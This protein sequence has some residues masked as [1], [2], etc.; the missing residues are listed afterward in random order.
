VDG[1]VVA[2]T[3]FGGPPFAPL[4]ELVF[5]RKA[6]MLSALLAARRDRYLGACASEWAEAN[7]AA[8]EAYE[9]WRDERFLAA[10]EPEAPAVSPD[11]QPG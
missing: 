2:R 3:L 7:A 8:V 9:K 6:G 10:P 1:W 11:P 5:A 4:D